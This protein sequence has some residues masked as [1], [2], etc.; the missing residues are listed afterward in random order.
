MKTAMLMLSTAVAAAGCATPRPA[1]VDAAPVFEAQGAAFSI[2]APPGWMRQG[3]Q[4]FLLATRD[5]P[6]LQR[7]TVSRHEI[8]KPLANTKKVLSAG[9]LPQEMAEVVADD[10]ASSQVAV[11][12]QVL[13]NAPASVGGA[14]GFRLTV[15]YKHRDGLKYKLVVYGT[16]VGK[17]FY[18]LAYS[19][20]ER[21]YFD[22]D[23][24]TFEEVARSFRP[25]PSAPGGP[26]A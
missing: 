23:L 25:G 10:I 18:R 24:A 17:W 7:I 19:A 26:P 14:P 13:E 22:M 21:H 4:E 20:A 3:S 12:A 9:M 1:W 8:G 2:Q 6:L 11:G 15:S 16:V 5:G